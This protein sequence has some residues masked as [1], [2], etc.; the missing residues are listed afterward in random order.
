M[1][2]YHFATG[3]RHSRLRFGQIGFYAMKD[4]VT[5]LVKVQVEHSARSFPLWLLRELNPATPGWSSSIYV[6]AWPRRVGSGPGET[7]LCCMR[8]Q[9]KQ[10]SDDAPLQARAAG[11]A[12]QSRLAQPLSKHTRPGPW[13]DTRPEPTARQTFLPPWLRPVPAPR[14]TSLLQQNAAT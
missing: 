1:C 10:A 14:A 11:C 6:P 4:V 9:G 2:A 13:L 7:S 8:A 12:F 5:S 3:M